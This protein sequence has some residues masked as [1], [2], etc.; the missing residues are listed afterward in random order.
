M[1]CGVSS[2][3]IQEEVDAEVRVSPH[4]RKLHVDDNTF[5]ELMRTFDKIDRVHDKQLSLSEFL[6][7]YGLEETYFAKLIFSRMDFGHTGSLDFEEYAVS[8]WDFLTCDLNQFIFHLYDHNDSGSLTA[9]QFETL[10]LDAYNMTAGSNQLLDKL[11]RSKDTD[12]DGS[13]SFVEFEEAVAHNKTMQFPGYVIQKEFMDRNGG[14]GLWT[15]LRDQRT[16]QFGAMS[17]HDILKIE[18]FLDIS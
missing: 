12:G 9:A 2:E 17:L 18:I 16:E 6:N 4:L 10:V 15:R 5:G 3:V 14:E 1:G 8:L 13:I 7:F 11:I